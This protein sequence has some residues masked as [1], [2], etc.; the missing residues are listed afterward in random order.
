[1]SVLTGS[2]FAVVIIGGLVA[3]VVPVVMSRR[4]WQRLGW[5]E[6]RLVY[7]G[8][9]WG[10]SLYVVA[11]VTLPLVGLMADS[12]G[13]SDVFRIHGTLLGVAG[14]VTQITVAVGM[15]RLARRV[16]GGPR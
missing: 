1:M 12:V 11:A 2:I 15:Y 9:L 8:F 3:I 7:R 14:G 5:D 4:A 10:L 16:A 13:A 6:L